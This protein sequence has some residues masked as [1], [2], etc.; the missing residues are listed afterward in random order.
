MR[1]NRAYLLRDCN[2]CVRFLLDGKKMSGYGAYYLFFTNLSALCI[3]GGRFDRG[4]FIGNR[5]DLWEVCGKISN[6]FFVFSYF[7]AFVIDLSLF[8]TGCFGLIVRN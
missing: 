5:G 2:D 7:R 6:S 4:V 8:S 3:S 1:K